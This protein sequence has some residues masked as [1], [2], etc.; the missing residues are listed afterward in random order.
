VNIADAI[1][2]GINRIKERH[3]KEWAKEADFRKDMIDGFKDHG[4]KREAEGTPKQIIKNALIEAG[5]G[6]NILVKTKE[7]RE[8]RTILDWKKLAGQEGSIDKMKENVSKVLEKKGFSKEE[9]SEMQKSLSDEYNNLRASVIEKSINELNK[10]NKKILTE[11][12]KTAA[13]KLSEL[14]NYGL[15]EQDPAQ[16]DVLLAKAIGI[17]RLNEGRFKKV[18]E[19]GKALETLYG[20]SFNGKK[21]NDLE[22]KTAI[23]SIE[24]KMRVILH[25]EAGQHGSSALKMADMVRTYMDAT[26]RMIL[27][28]L[29][30]GVQNPLAGLQQVTMSNI[31]SFLNNSGSTKELRAQKREVAKAIYKDMV[32]AGGV[33]FGDVNTTFVSRGNLDAYIA[34]MSDNK[35]FHAIAST[36]IGKT[37]LDAVDSFFKAKLTDQK[38]IHNLIKILTTPRLVDGKRVA[39][40]SNSDAI[41]YVSE[42][43]TGQSF[44]AAK[45]TATEIIQKVNEG[46]KKIVGDS[47]AYVTRLAN[48]IVK[49]ALINGSVITPEQ[50]TAAYNAAYKSAGRSMGHVAN[51][52]LSEGVQSVSGKIEK[53]INDA[54]KDKEYKKAALLTYQ[55]IFFRNILNPFVGGGTNWVVLK[56]EKNG[57]GLIS[58]LY[59]GGKTKLDMTTEVGLRQVEKS[60]YEEAR[61]RDA[62]MRGAIGGTTALLMSM[63]WFG[64][65]S[66]DD[67]RKW[68]NKNKW[69]AKYLDYVT[70]EFILASMAVKNKELGYYVGTLINKNMAYDNAAKIISGL[71]YASKGKN[72]KAAGKLGEAFGAR[73]GVPIPWRLARDFQNI[74]L[75]AQGEEPYKINNKPSK[76]FFEGMLKAGMF[77]Y[78]ENNPI[79]K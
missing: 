25:D 49:A 33:N 48:D 55:S 39:P 10:R 27:N 24:E 14:Y 43:L 65:A 44:E 26:Q 64:V 2:L 57:L 71:D 58:G 51:N 68:R 53:S 79:N 45:K 56:L 1:E 78:I 21:L 62:F 63:L 15:F 23:Q 18:Y 31:D 3:G 16:Y 37:T 6:R 69:A 8:A 17:D 60:L 72:D 41:N 59:N 36:A 11:D 4:I 40:M 67:Y 30:Q 38:F 77:D 28:S 13:K 19:L 46:G 47:E 29:G 7:G 5:F 76:T 70:P 74:W 75:G 42:K 20:S 66:T 54:I 12:Q 22:L 34:K 50:V 32:L 61:D 73:F 9:I 35:L 52:P